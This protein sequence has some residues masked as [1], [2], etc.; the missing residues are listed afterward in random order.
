MSPVPV[1]LSLEEEGE[2]EEEE[3]GRWIDVKLFFKQV[4]CAGIVATW[5]NVSAIYSSF[6]YR[7]ILIVLS[8]SVKFSF[9]FYRTTNWLRIAYR[10]ALYFC[11]FLLR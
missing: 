1:E 10:P 7:Y 11:L 5:F 2:E 9:C 6:L 4:I 8:F 3:E